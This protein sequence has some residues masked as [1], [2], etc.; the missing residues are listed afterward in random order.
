MERLS[1]ETRITWLGL[2]RTRTDSCSTQSGNRRPAIWCSI[3][4][5]VARSTALQ[6]EVIDGPP[7]TR[8]SAEIVLSLSCG[9]DRR[10]TDSRRRAHIASRELIAA[11]G[12]S[13]VVRAT[14]VARKCRNVVLPG[15]AARS[16]RRVSACPPW[17]V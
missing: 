17:T 5:H 10:P 6:R 1:I 3:E 2:R 16:W 14:A 13:R 15:V 4:P 11:T 9:Q 7:T 8:R 12:R